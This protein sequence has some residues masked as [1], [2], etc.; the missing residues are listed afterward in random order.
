MFSKSSDANCSIWKRVNNIAY[1]VNTRES[2][3]QQIWQIYEGE[4]FFFLQICQRFKT[5]K[6][7]MLNSHLQQTSLSLYLNK[8]A[9]VH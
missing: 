1:G 5:V 8:H 4:T 2:G 9:P 6:Y 7:I 3:I